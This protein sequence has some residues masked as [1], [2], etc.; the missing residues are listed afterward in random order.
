MTR[1]Q[2]RRLTLRSIVMADA[3]AL[4]RQGNDFAVARM[5]GRMP[6][7]Y[8]LQHAQNFIASLTSGSEVVFTIVG[9]N[10]PMGT[11]GIIPRGDGREEIGYWL[12]RRY[13]GRGIASEMAQALIAHVFEARGAAQVLVAHCDDNIASRRLILGQG[14]EYVRTSDAWCAA[15][16]AHV[17][18]LHY[19][20]SRE[21][22]ERRKGPKR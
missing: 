14:F 15:R 16:A 22:W 18:C 3:P 20:L 5:L 6:H 7:P 4:V 19:A 1:I 9:E 11:C 17:P 10:S 2:T 12:G 21:R 13:W 8:R